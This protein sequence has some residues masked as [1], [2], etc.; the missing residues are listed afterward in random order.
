MAS[1]VCSKGF[2]DKA[3]KKLQTPLGLQA[4][5][6]WCIPFSRFINRVTFTAFKNSIIYLSNNLNIGTYIL[7]TLIFDKTSTFNIPYVW[8]E[9]ERYTFDIRQ[10]YA[11]YNTLAYIK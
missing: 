6:T 10:V 2:N 8:R 3:A 7:Y 1:E 4:V 9:R 5:G 11:D